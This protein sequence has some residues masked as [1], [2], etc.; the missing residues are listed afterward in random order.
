M[1]CLWVVV[2]YF[3]ERSHPSTSAFSTS[4]AETGVH[5]GR[6]RGSRFLR[7]QYEYELQRSRGID[8]KSRIALW[9]TSGLST[10]WARGAYGAP[11]QTHIPKCLYLYGG[12][13]GS[14]GSLHSARFSSMY[15]RWKPF[16]T[17]ICK[18]LSIIFIRCFYV[19]VRIYFLGI[20]DLQRAVKNSGFPN[21]VVFIVWSLRS[22]R[23]ILYAL[24]RFYVYVDDTTQICITKREGV[25]C[26]QIVNRTLNLKQEQTSLESQTE[27]LESQTDTLESQTETL[28]LQTG[29]MS[30]TVIQHKAR[31]TKRS[32]AYETV[33]GVRNGL[34]RTKRM[35][36]DH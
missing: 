1:R 14:G 25:I 30:Y 24:Y 11:L 6:T 32:Q 36:V 20:H 3:Y 35:S 5:G 34:R 29:N 27:T 22:S 28:E 19:G 12:T 17:S 4:R 8:Y 2:G 10:T 33:S 9:A 15:E 13:K 18:Q 21:Y 7:D 31:R 26:F 23:I 16:F